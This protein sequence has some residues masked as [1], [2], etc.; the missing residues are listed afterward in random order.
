MDQ[1]IWIRAK[2]LLG[3]GVMLTALPAQATPFII[4][5]NF[6]GDLT[7]SQKDIFST[8]ASTWMGLLPGYKPGIS[9]PQLTID[10]KTSSID[11]VG[12]ILGAAGPTWVTNQ[13][14]YV[15]STNGSMEFDSDDITNLENAGLL[16]AV[17]L[18]EIAHVIGFGT[19]WTDNGVYANETGAYTGANALAAYK[20]EFNQLNAASI[21]VELGG[22]PGTADGHWDEVDGGGVN[23][24]VVSSFGDMSFELMTGW[25]NAPYYISNTTIQSF[26]DIGYLTTSIPEPGT[27]FSFAAGV[28]FIFLLRR[29]A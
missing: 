18:H 24:G 13:G 16:L 17:V 12:G 8:A 15:L 27:L 26:A 22:G 9:I 23:T 4:N 29:R 21:P 3:L 20:A 6:S 2:L 25:I 7:A 1:K 10:A 5:L 14:G 28:S 11:G 19:L